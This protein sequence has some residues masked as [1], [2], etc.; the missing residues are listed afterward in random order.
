[1]EQGDVKLEDAVNNMNRKM[2]VFIETV[3]SMDDNN[4]NNESDA[5]TLEEI[6]N[7][8]DDEDWD[9]IECKNRSEWKMQ[10]PNPNCGVN[11]HA[12]ERDEKHDPFSVEKAGVECN[13]T[14]AQFMVV[15]MKKSMQEHNT[16]FAFVQQHLHHKGTIAFGEKGKEAATKELKQQCARKSFMT[17]A[18][19]ALSK[20]KRDGACKINANAP[21]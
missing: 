20:A 3:R 17:I 19:E 5:V 13:H 16:E 1:M 10:N 9:M 12:K 2:D 11:Q 8:S 6:D 18:T 21:D 7:E 4:G 15:S 14:K